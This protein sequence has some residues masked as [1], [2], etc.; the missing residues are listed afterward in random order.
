MARVSEQDSPCISKIVWSLRRW[1]WDSDALSLAGERGV[2]RGWG[3]EPR[4][5][6]LRRGSGQSVPGAPIS[7]EGSYLAP[8]R[9]TAPPQ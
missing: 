9:G 8:G 2:I 3:P 6:G 7:G 5:T 4:T 1:E